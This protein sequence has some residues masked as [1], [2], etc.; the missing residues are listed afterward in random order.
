MK[1]N[2]VNLKTEKPYFQ[3]INLSIKF[4]HLIFTLF[5]WIKAFFNIKMLT[6]IFKASTYFKTFFNIFAHNNFLLFLFLYLMNKY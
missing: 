6:A 1:N 5:S 3:C 2:K 4:A